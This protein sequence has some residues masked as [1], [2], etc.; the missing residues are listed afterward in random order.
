MV[1]VVPALEAPALVVLVS[2][3]LPSGLAASED[4]LVSVVLLVWEALGVL[5]VAELLAVDMALV[6]MVAL[7]EQLLSLLSTIKELVWVV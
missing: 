6:A 7:W 3:A 2:L 1:L 5:V 4:P